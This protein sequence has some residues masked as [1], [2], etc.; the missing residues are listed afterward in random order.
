MR[1]TKLLVLAGALTIVGSGCRER[2]ARLMG[3]DSSV[4]PPEPRAEEPS[5]VHFTFTGPTSAVFSWRGNNRTMRI[6]AK[7]ERPR[8][9]DAHDAK[10]GPFSMPGQWQ[11][12]EITGLQP[13]TQYG[14][15]VGRPRLPVPSFFRSPPTAGSAGFNFAAMADLGAS[16]EFPVSPTHR[17]VALGEPAFVFVLGGLTL[18]DLRA[19]TSVDRHF[20]DIMGWSRVA[21][22]LPVWSEHEWA[23]PKRDD[24][25]NYKGRFALPNAQASP[26]APEQGCCGEDW[27]WLDYGN[28]RF[29]AYPEPYTD[30]TWDDWA[31]KAAPLMAEAESSPAI[32][33]IVTLGHR[34]AYSSAPEGGDARLR[35]VLDGFGARFSKYVL[36]LSGHARVY[37]RTKPQAHVVHI[38]V[39]PGGMDLARADTPCGWKDCKAPAFTA[40]RALHRGM[41]RFS[42]RPGLL[43]VDAFCSTATPGRDD[44][45]C[46]EGEILDSWSAKGASPLSR[47]LPTK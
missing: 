30:A 35:A 42:S 40:F 39:P 29:V 46:V 45:R 31:A 22:Y 10:P 14:Y 23:S 32:E 6:W 44:V 15:E 12:A 11:E 1:L 8:T 5:Q 2:A 34:P 43:K 21:A 16:M 27:W 47:A 13:D 37:E 9:I 4:P 36:N 20:E 24:L 38:T 26:G 3:V 17:L 33:M 19:Q 28:I 7:G 25:R 41:L 18:A